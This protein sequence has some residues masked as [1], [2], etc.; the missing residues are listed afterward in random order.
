[1]KPEKVFEVKP[2]PAA[3]KYMRLLYESGYSIHICSSRKENLFRATIEWLQKEGFW[4]YIDVSHT[5]SSS[6]KGPEYKVEV[7]RKTNPVAAFDDTLDVIEALASVVPVLY[8][9]DKPWNQT[10]KLPKNVTRSKDFAHAVATFLK[11]KRPIS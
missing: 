4:Q 3:A 1:M 8:M 11:I 2:D 9:I 6:Q 5:R 10:D 7:A